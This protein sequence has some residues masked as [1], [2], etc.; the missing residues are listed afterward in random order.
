MSLLD[1]YHDLDNIKPVAAD[2][3][4]VLF[5]SYFESLSEV[6]SFVRMDLA[7]QRVS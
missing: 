2:G 3:W 5:D 7:P 4:Y 6:D 1:I